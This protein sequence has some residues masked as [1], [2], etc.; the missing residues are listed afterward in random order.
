MVNLDNMG[1][2]FFIA[3]ATYFFGY[4]SLGIGIF[5]IMILGVFLARPKRAPVTVKEEVVQ[6]LKIKG[7][8]VLEP[9]VIESTR[10]P[11]FRIPS[12]MRIRVKP[13]WSAYSWFEKAARGVGQVSRFMFLQSLWAGRGKRS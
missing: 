1:V 7:A 9:I 4:R 8:N 12:E 13:N 5:V 11:P 6:G 3:A 10:G 2:V